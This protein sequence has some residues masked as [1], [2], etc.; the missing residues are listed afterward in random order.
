MKR[1]ETP[2]ITRIRRLRTS[3]DA[4]PYPFCGFECRPVTRHRLAFTGRLT[5]WSVEV[6]LLGRGCSLTAHHM[7][8]RFGQR[9]NGIAQAQ[10]H[11]AR[12]A[13]APRD[14]ARLE[15]RQHRSH[16]R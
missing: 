7:P 9:D 1:R 2:E 11:P 12:P 13:W 8:T 5:S 10:Q 15:R 16:R 14:E 3:T 6:R 4:R